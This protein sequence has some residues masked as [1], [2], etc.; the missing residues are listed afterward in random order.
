MAN[1]PNSMLSQLSPEVARMLDEQ[2]RQKALQQQLAPTDY[3]NSGMG[4]FL[5]AASGAQKSLGAGASNLVNQVNGVQAPMGMEETRAVESQKNQQV[6]TDALSQAK[7][8]T[9]SARLLNAAERLEKSNN[10]NAIAYATQLRTQAGSIAVQEQ[11]LDLQKQRL[12]IDKTEAENR[13]DEFKQR[14]ASTLAGQELQRKQLVASTTVQETVVDS[15]G[16]R[17]QQITGEDGSVNFS[18]IAG[19]PSTPVG[20]I[21]TINEIVTNQQNKTRFDLQF[22]GAYIEERKAVQAQL[23]DTRAVFNSADNAYGL[24]KEL[25]KAGGTTGGVVT[26]TERKIKRYLGIEDNKTIKQEPL[27]KELGM[28]IAANLKATFGG[29]QITDSE[30]KFLE[31]NMISILDTPEVILEKLGATMEVSKKGVAKLTDLFSAKG[32][33]ELTELQGKYMEQDYL[34]V[35]EKYE[36]NFEQPTASTDQITPEMA[37][38]RR[39]MAMRNNKNV[40]GYTSV[41]NIR[42]R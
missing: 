25:Q 18:P 40:S 28:A 4:M 3:G 26:E 35:K 8:A 5:S 29:S 15:E 41:R 7:G 9:Q 17:F 16:N 11:T 39:M 38:A 13:A 22:N 24:L 31:A 42:N 23:K 27:K 20:N 32:Y 12:S 30:R 2:S 14:Q 36:L 21:S 1:Q 19:A 34:D 33:S 10:P 37:E 6:V